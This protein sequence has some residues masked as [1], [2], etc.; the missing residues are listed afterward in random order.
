M[1]AHLLWKYY[2]QKKRRRAFIAGVAITLVK[3]KKSIR[4]RHYITKE[5]LPKTSESAWK[6]LFAKGHDKAFLE[7]MGVT[8][9]LFNYILDAMREL[10]KGRVLSRE[11]KL[12]LV[13]H[14]LNST[15]K[16]KTLCQVF[17]CAP[18]T[19]QRCLME[20]IVEL[21]RA[22]QEVP[23]GRVGFP[24][25][26]EAKLFAQQITKREPRLKNVFGFV[27]GV[28]FPLEEPA[29]QMEQSRYY[30][31]WKRMCCVG[32]VFGFTPDGCIC[33]ARINYPGSCNDKIIAEDLDE[34]IE[35]ALPEQFKILADSGFTS[36]KRILTPYKSDDLAKTNKSQEILAMV[37]QHNSVVSIRQSA[38]W[39]M[40]GIQGAFARLK[41]ALPLN[42]RK[43]KLIIETC[44]RLFNLRTR[45]LGINQIK[46]VYDPDYSP[47]IV[48]VTLI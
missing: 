4:N 46:V 14:Y 39:G 48:H 45:F 41:T 28:S 16:C 37:E 20:S 13:L 5:V 11:A 21:L 33:Y 15:M 23:E 7:T 19:L 26:A 12:G 38:E 30:N 44:V 9:A 8:R 27:D 24:S 29:N 36:S 2:Q 42:G 18:T 10:R 3:Y 31:G 34:K 1:R 47:V 40:R 6:S 25:Q 43:R 22:L 32:N 35:E 17:A